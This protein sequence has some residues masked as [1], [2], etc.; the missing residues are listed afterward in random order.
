MS[1]IVFRFILSNNIAGTKIISE[2]DG[3]REAKLK[4]ERHA[5]FHSLVEYFEGDFIFYG[6]SGSYDGGLNYIL[7]VEH[8]QGFNA[9]IVITIDISKNGGSSYEN[10]FVGQL[11]LSSIRHLK[12]NKISVPI[13]R[14]SMWSKLIA[15]RNIPVDLS[16]T[17]DLDGNAVTA[18]P[19]VTLNLIS[20]KVRQIYQADFTQE[21]ND[22]REYNIPAGDYGQISFEDVILDE[23]EERFT[24][25]NIDNPEIPGE[26][27]AA[28]YAGAYLVN[29][30]INVSTTPLAVLGSAVTDLE[31]R[32]KVNDNA[33]VSATKTN[34]GVNGVN[35][36]TNF[37][38]NSTINLNK[39]DLLKIY[40]ENTSVSNKQ[41]FV[42]GKPFSTITVTA[43]T[44]FEDSTCQGY[45]LHDAFA[46]VI[47]RI[48]G[49]DA[50]YSEVLGSTLTNMRTY[51]ADGCNWYYAI[52]RGLQIRGYSLSEKA[53]SISFNDLWSGADPIFNLG[54]GYDVVSGNQVL[55]LEEK[56]FFYDNTGVSTSLSNVRDAERSYD[57]STIW[58]KITIGFDKWQSENIS[59]LDDPQTSHVYTDILQVKIPGENA[60]GGEINVKSRFI[61]ASIAWELTRRQTL[62]KNKDYKFDNDTFILSLNPDDVSADVYEPEF[63]ENLSTIE[64]IISPGHRYNLRL[65]PGRSFARWRNVFNG[66]LQK[67]LNTSFRFVWGEGNYDMASTIVDTGCR[68]DFGGDTMFEGGDIAVTNDYLHLPDIYNIDVN[69]DYNDYISMRS[70]RNKSINIS[71]TNTNHRKYFLKELEYEICKGSC[72]G[73]AWS[74]N[75]NIY[76]LLTVVGSVIPSREKFSGEAYGLQCVVECEPRVTED[77]DIR[78]TE[79]DIQRVAESFNCD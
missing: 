75:A 1:N 10:L 18:T 37:T 32:I 29:F 36:S 52:T 41:F 61:A 5:E 42:S 69:L 11:D 59:G 73:V 12:D 62:E 22:Y 4:L 14:N 19:P 54:L 7:S 77:D 57:E 64:N 35:G 30:T 6:A 16:S 23:I 76:D 78:V 72:K 2:P 50:F 74:Y 33:A 24:Y 79:D 43:D 47:R 13:I 68:G 55:R 27:F 63:N 45:L 15:R 44:T 67:Y 34:G 9:V 26:L 56:D 58:N 40:F 53:I 17:V 3:W 31:V 51:L 46:G 66:C 39:N 20:Q 60:I 49:E 38:Y 70:N 25:V 8:E 65:T 21:E 71:N 48:V 28:E